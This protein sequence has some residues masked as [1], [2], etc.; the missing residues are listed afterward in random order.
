MESIRAQVCVLGGGPAGA[1]T[2][3]RLA[4]LGHSV[5]VVEKT[6]FPRDRVGESVPGSVLPLLDVLGVRDAVETEA[7]LRPSL[8]IV[9]WKGE[10]DIREVPF[11][12][13]F[14]VNRARFDEVLL[15]AARDAGGRVLQPARVMHHSSNENESHTVEVR[16]GNGVVV[17]IESA[18]LVDATGR[19]SSFAGRVKRTGQRTT[20]LYAYWRRLSPIQHETAIEACPSEWLWGAALPDNV[21]NAAVFIDASR[22]RTGIAE[23][24]SAERFY[25]SLIHSSE[26][27]STWVSGTRAT[28]V[29][30]CDATPLWHE[31]PVQNR[32]V[33]VGDASFSIDPLAAQ[34]VHVAFG[35]ALHAAAMIHT[36]LNRPS[37]EGIAEQFYVDR[38]RQSMAFHAGAA[39]SL[40]A[41]AARKYQTPFWLTRAGSVR[42]SSE[43]GRAVR[44]E[45]NDDTVVRVHPSVRFQDVPV[46]EGDFIV[47]AQGICAP[48]FRVPVVF[49]DDV[50]IALLLTAISG[51]MQCSDI[52]RT[53]SC[54]AP[55]RKAVRILNYMLHRDILQV[56]S[57]TR[58]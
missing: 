54:T 21:L 16:T 8:A 20:A 40:Y 13:G 11:P 45:W 55:P 28:R 34:G 57:T 39:C 51:T 27:L 41:D 4:L 37:D 32:I 12:S 49:L 35:S 9:R 43:E 14:H 15:R 56:F 42:E 38:Q 30:V 25:D 50:P 33:K 22:L 36:I 58:D 48:G 5:V 10:N 26:L 47:R 46:I 1:A 3:R 19:G 18:F 2:A 7:F 52:I 31:R 17:R 29:H 53:W 44:V 6:A 24:A 23:H